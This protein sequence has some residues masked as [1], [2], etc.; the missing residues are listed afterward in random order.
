M[1]HCL[2]MLFEV[3]RYSPPKHRQ[4]AAAF[5]PLTLHSFFFLLAHA[6]C[7]FLKLSLSSLSLLLLLFSDDVYIFSFFLP[8]QRKSFAFAFRQRK[9]KRRKKVEVKE[10]LAWLMISECGLL[11]HWRERR[12]RREREKK[13]SSRGKRVHGPCNYVFLCGRIKIFS[14]QKTCVVLKFLAFFYL[15]LILN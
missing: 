10:D 5:L 14:V 8:W 4:S 11:G 7:P 3:A 15:F 9:K 12:R 1:E 6:L 2:S 13:R